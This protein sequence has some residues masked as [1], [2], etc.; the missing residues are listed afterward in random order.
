VGKALIGRLKGDKVKVKTP[1]GS[2]SL[3]ILTIR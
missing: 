1:S 3:V 2:R